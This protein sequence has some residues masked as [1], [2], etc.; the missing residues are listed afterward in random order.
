MWEMLGAGFFLGISPFFWGGGGFELPYLVFTGLRERATRPFRGIVQS[1][2]WALINATS[3]RVG[4]YYVNAKLKVYD[5]F[6]T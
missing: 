4:V 1:A 2:G 6:F 5:Y 3:R